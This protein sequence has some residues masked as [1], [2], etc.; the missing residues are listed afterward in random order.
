[1]RE[2]E[3]V[4][5]HVIIFAS[6]LDGIWSC[7]HATLEFLFLRVTEV[8]QHC[9]NKIFLD[10]VCGM[11]WVILYMAIKFLHSR[12]WKLYSYDVPMV[13][14]KGHRHDIF[15]VYELQTV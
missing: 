8:A 15:E 14:S 7:T 9:K 5:L 11:I 1:M 2:E 12:F 13:H 4:F 10:M 6:S 3:M